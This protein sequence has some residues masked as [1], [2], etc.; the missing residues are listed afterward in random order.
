M[1]R[2][3]PQSW[4]FTHLYYPD[5]DDNEG[6]VESWIIKAMSLPRNM[7][8]QR[9]QFHFNMFYSTATVFAFMNSVVYWF[10]TRQ[11]D[12]AGGAEGLLKVTTATG[13]DFLTA[14]V[15]TANAATMGPLP[16]APCM[17]SPQHCVRRS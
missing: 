9:K 10:I 8:S 11:H 1:Y 2:L 4:T 15:L 7:A 3:C 12:A 6:G 14:S 17:V 16:D 5:P 13:G